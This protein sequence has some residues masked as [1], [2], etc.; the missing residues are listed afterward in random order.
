VRRSR[1]HCT[2]VGH[3]SHCTLVD[4]FTSTLHHASHV[5]IQAYFRAFNRSPLALL[6]WTFRTRYFH[7]LQGLNLAAIKFS[8]ER[9]VKKSSLN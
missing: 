3:V 5:L 8:F 6:K 7:Q 1:G 4:I 9:K 2:L